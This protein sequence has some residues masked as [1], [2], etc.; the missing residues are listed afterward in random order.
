MQIDIDDLVRYLG[1]E[2]A[3]RHK[4]QEEVKRLETELAVLKAELDMANHAVDCLEADLE[5]SRKVV[6]DVA[7]EMMDG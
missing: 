3:L 7:K 4:A 5:S 6:R 2:S 1:T